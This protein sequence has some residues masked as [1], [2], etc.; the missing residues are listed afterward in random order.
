MRIPEF[1]SR[2]SELF[3]ETAKAHH[4]AFVT[5]DGNDPEWPIWYADYIQEPI[6]EI[7]DTKFF[8]SSLIYCLMNADFEYTAREVDVQ[9]QKFYSKHFIGHFAPTDTPIEDHLALYYI[10]TCPFCKMVIK[11]IN[12]LGIEVE[13]LNINEDSTYH[14]ELVSVRD[15]ATVPV[16]RITSP[17]C[18]DR[19]M[20][21]SRDI[22]S[23]L[24]STYK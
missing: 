19:W 20:P 24:K 1:E 10:P 11:T 18:D 15:R 17:D 4:D 8:K 12:Q 9:W 23:Y 14:D 2:L 7:L 21:E 16:L 3:T 22:I 6:S 13:L 5:T